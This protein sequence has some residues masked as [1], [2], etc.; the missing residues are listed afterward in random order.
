ML[1]LGRFWQVN[2]NLELSQ[3]FSNFTASS[4]EFLWF[5]TLV[6]IRGLLSY[7]EIREQKWIMIIEN[8]FIVLQNISNGDLYNTLLALETM[9]EVLLPLWLR[10]LQNMHSEWSNHFFRYRRKLTSQFVFTYWNKV[11]RFQ[12]KTIRQMTHMYILMVC[13]SGIPSSFCQLDSSIFA[14][15]QPLSSLPLYPSS[16]LFVRH[17]ISPGETTAPPSVFHLHS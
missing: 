15:L 13:Y 10:Y 4:L 12:L 1:L 11:L 7:F 17:T 9:V 3:L 16:H 6:I 14:L 2:W 5:V 8:H